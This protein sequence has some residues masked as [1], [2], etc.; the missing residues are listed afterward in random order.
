MWACVG[1]VTIVALLKTF[2][3]ELIVCVTW[4][5]GSMNGI[6]YMLKDRI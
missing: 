3:V 5:G 6:S 1:S 2:I 4:V